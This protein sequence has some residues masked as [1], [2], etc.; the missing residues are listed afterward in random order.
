MEAQR[1]ANILR[2]A[3]LR[4]RGR[5][6]RSIAQVLGV[7]VHTAYSYVWTHFDQLKRDA[8]ESLEKVRHLELV[9]LD[10]YLRKLEGIIRM[11]DPEAATKAIATA[12]RVQERR[13]KLTGL[14]AP[15]R[16]ELTVPEPDMDDAQMLSQLEAAA[17]QVKQRMAHERNLDS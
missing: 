12:L 13:A 16:T 10:R 11:H 9:R 17:A 3:K 5:S 6:Y 14:D 8:T 1:K 15:V 4:E 2:A 7:D